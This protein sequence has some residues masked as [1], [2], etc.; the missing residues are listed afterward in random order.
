MS[1][2]TTLK[3][4]FETGDKPTE[5]QFADLID[6]LSLTTETD[7]KQDTLISGTNI[8]TINSESLLGSGDISITSTPAGSDTQIQFNDGGAFG[9]SS[10]LTW[11]GTYLETDVIKVNGIRNLDGTNVISLYS[12]SGQGHNIVLDGTALRIKTIGQYDAINLLSTTNSVGIFETSPTARLQVKGTT[13]TSASTN[14]LLQNSSGTD[15]FKVT[16][17]GNAYFGDSSG[18]LNLKILGGEIRWDRST[19]DYGGG[20]LSAQGNEKIEMYTAGQFDVRIGS[21]YHTFRD[22]GLYLGSNGIPTARLHVKGAD[23]LGTSYALKVVDSADGNL[24]SVANDGAATFSGNVGI[25]TTSPSYGLL[26]IEGDGVSTYTPSTLNYNTSIVGRNTSNWGWN[27]V[28]FTFSNSTI[29]DNVFSL[30]YNNDTAFFGIL[31]D[32]SSVQRFLISE[33]GVG[34]GNAHSAATIS[35]ALHVKGSTDTSATTNLLLQNSSGDDLFKVTDDGAAT[36][37]GN[38]GIGTTPSVNA[39]EVLSLQNVSNNACY[40]TM[41]NNASDVMKVGIDAFNSFIDFDNAFFFKKSGTILT[42]LT[43]TG[44]GIGETSPTAFLDIKASTTS[45]AHLRLRDGVDPTSPNDGDIWNDGTN[46]KVRLGGTT[47]TLDKT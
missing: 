47:Y 33:D 36:F 38:V 6:S 21:T 43:S 20:R 24:L 22:N 31:D 28:G 7:A 35:A 37:S 9:A 44:L 40:I 39:Y 18:S 23:L 2:R 32:S 11:D 1:N 46:L 19:G 5:T 45:A 26:Q 17:D 3:T 13:S 42:T 25:G 4:Y 34:I 14:L 29:G 10:G 16:D 30:V 15:L 8:K 27:G 41:E 12:S